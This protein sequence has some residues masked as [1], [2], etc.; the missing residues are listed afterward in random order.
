[1]DNPED[2]IGSLTMVKGQ[3][4]EDQSLS[5]VGTGRSTEIGRPGAEQPERML[6]RDTLGPGQWG[7]LDSWRSVLGIKTGWAVDQSYRVAVG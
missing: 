2:K 3:K 7:S 1:M 6:F 4:T 5:S